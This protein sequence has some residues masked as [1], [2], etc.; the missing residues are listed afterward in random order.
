MKRGVLTISESDLDCSDQIVRSFFGLIKTNQR[1]K[2]F[3]RLCANAVELS[4]SL[5]GLDVYYRSGNSDCG[6]VGAVKGKRQNSCRRIVEGIDRPDLD[7][8]ASLLNGQE[9]VFR[10]VCEAMQA[11]VFLESL[12]RAK[13]I[14]ALAFQSSMYSDAITAEEGQISGR[15]STIG[16][17]LAVVVKANLLPPSSSCSCWAPTISRVPS[18][19]PYTYSTGRQP[20]MLQE[21]RD[22]NAP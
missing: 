11:I 14:P 12:Y 18:A 4:G 7:A 9:P 10:D 20:H 21:P 17:F 16:N 13:A 15:A 5:C 2:P 1:L 8:K 6:T 3:A 22:R 19:K